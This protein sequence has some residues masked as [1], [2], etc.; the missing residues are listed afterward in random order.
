ML[1]SFNSWFGYYL[2]IV[3]NVSFFGIPEIAGALEALQKAGA[4]ALRWLTHV[5]EETQEIMSM[6]F[7]DILG[8]HS[9]AP[10]DVIGDWFRGTRGIMLDMYRHPDKLIKAMERLVPI[11][12]S[13]GANLSKRMGKPVAMLMLH[14][15]LDSFMSNEQY[16]KFY[17]PTLRKVMMGLIDQGLVPMPLFEG[18]Y[19]SRLEII[20]DIPKGKAIYWFEEVDIYKAKEILGDTV[21]FRGNVPG[22]LLYAGNPQQV[23]NYVKEL[24]DV[25]GKGGGLMVDCGIWFDEA[26]H[27]N[28]KAMIDFTKEYEVYK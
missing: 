24:I 2:G 13:M 27:E 19:T 4:E 21:C 6:G 15:G 7:P 17:W 22:S 9:A 12:I 25:V 14:K 28:V 1:P 5:R 10:F 3:G 11:Q 8:G 20:K 26:K 23:K 18:E 16:K